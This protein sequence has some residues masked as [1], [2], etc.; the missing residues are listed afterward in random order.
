MKPTVYIET[1][2]AGHLTSRLPTDIVVAGQ[3]LETRRW[4]NESRDQF[5]LFT[6]QAVLVEVGRGDPVAAA[7]RLEAIKG[8]PLIPITDSAKALAAALIT[9]NA[10]PAKARVDASI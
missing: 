7:E 5:D 8:V 6:S 1:T 2:I 10:V 4:W 9:Q 3:M